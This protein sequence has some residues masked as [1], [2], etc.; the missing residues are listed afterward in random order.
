MSQ[1]QNNLIWIDLEMTGLAVISNTILEIAVV[2]TDADLRELGRWPS[3]NLGQAIRQP[4]SVLAGMDEW[5]KMTHSQTGL[6]ER[7]R[8]SS[9]DLATTQRLAL[10]LVRGY[11]PDPG[12]DRTKGCPLAGN[13]IGIDRAFLQAYMPDLE[14]HTSYRNVDVSTIKEL[15]NRW[16]PDCSYDKPEAGRH[17]AMADILASIEELRYYRS[18]VF[19]VK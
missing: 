7:V 13:S 12:P 3:G 11:C 19:R 16:Y 2:I 10:E 15:V 17:T 1:D 9:F 8:E 18:R 6:L 4:E 5:G 14:R